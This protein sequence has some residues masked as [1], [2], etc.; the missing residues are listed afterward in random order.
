VLTQH[1]DIGRTGQN[2]TE[3]TL[4]PANVTTANFG[5]L[6][7]LSVDGQTIAQ[8][9][10]MSSVNIGGASHRVVF[11]AT[12]HDSVYAFDADTGAKLWKASMLDAAH[13][14]AS[15][16][17]PEPQSDNGCGDI[18][19]LG[20]AAAEYG[21]TSTPVIDPSTGTLYLVAKTYEGTY[22][23]QRLHALDIT[24][25]NEK[26]SGPVTISASV[27]GTGS[28]SSNGTLNFDPRWENQ[29]S[30]LLL[31][32]GNVYAGFGSHCD[33]S[34]W[35]GWILG[36]NA[37][38]LAQT[39]KFVTTPNGS[40]SG[41]WMGGG[42]L[43]A[44][45]Q[46]GA[47]RLFP[48]TGN[49][50]YDAKTPYGT[51]NMDYGDDIL[52]L[53]VSSTGAL[54]VADA[55]TPYNQSTLSNED[56]DV[57]SGGAL[58]LPDQPGN[59]S[60]LLAQLGKSG[61]LYLV[62]RENLG[63][64]SG[65]TNNI[66]QQVSVS[67]GLWGLPA[68]WNGNLYVWPAGG[69]LSR[70]PLTNGTL[71]AQ[72][73]ET[74]PQQAS[75]WYGSTPAISSN[76]TQSGIVWAVDWSQS[77]QVLYAFDATNVSN[78]LWSSAQNT[79]RDSAG[80]QQKFAVPT[81]A[82]GNVFVGAVDQVMVYGMLTKPVPGF[83]LTAS[84]A[85]VTVAPGGS[86][87]AQ[88]T[89]T[90]ANGYTASPT[91]SVTG[92]PTGVTA[93]FSPASSNSG[94]TLTLTAASSATLTSAAAKVVVTASDGTLSHSAS[95]SLSVAN[96]A[97][98][99]E[100]DMSSAFNVYGIF[101]DGAT[102]S[103]GGLD[104]DG[105][106]YS[107]NLLGT[108]Q[109]GLGLPFKFGAAGAA[110]AASNVTVSLPSGYFTA[111]DFLGAGVNGNQTSQV[112]TVNYSDGTSS[113]FTQSMSDWFTPQSY[114]GETSV[115][116]MAH[117]GGPNGTTQAGPFYLYGYSFSLNSAKLVS[118]ITL[119][120]NRNV[121]VLAITLS[122]TTVTQTA[123]TITFAAIPT[124]TVG[125]PLTLSATA[126]S[127]LP[128]SF[129][130]STT[131]VCTVS[132]T[133]ATFLNTGSCTVAAS[134]AGNST[135]AAAKTVSQTFTVN[136]AAKTPQTITFG[137]ISAQTAGTTLT[138]SATASSGLAVSF[139]SS[140]A[141]VCTVNVATATL[142]T[143]GTCTIVA[144]Q[145][146][147][148]TYAAATSVTQSFTVN[149]VPLKSQSITFG[150]IPAQKVGTPLSLSASA[151]SGLTVSFASSTA[152]VCTVTATTA[153]FLTSGTCT[154]VASQAG[155]SSYAAATSV[156]QSFAVSGAAVSGPAAVDLS[157]FYN[158]NGIVNDGSNVSNGGLDA[159]GYAYSA[160][161]LGSSVSAQGVTFNFGAPGGVNALSGATISLPAGNF[162]TLHF[163]GAAVNGNQESQTFVVNYTDGSSSTFTQS[164]SDWFTP[165]NYPGESSISTM[166]Y[167]LTS[168]G[169]P[170]NRPFYLYGYTL[171]LNSSKTV[172]SLTLP[173]NRNV[174]VL[175]ITLS[176]VAQAAPDLSLNLA[177]TSITLTRS[178]FGY[179]NASDKVTIAALNGF[180]GN[181]AL[182]VTGL[183]AGWTA[184]FAPASVATAGS[185][186]LTIAP[187]SIT[188]GTYTLTVAA[189]SGSIKHVATLTVIAQ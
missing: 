80:S 29:R 14:A 161:L 155:N 119:P 178:F 170:D 56:A 76:G 132:G 153:T 172:K 141:S 168:N 117:R 24:T 138:L 28:G 149:P 163:A 93:S 66:V 7:T 142:I 32:N 85:V 83:T 136:A 127:G 58:L 15:G 134:Q 118:S 19:A 97:V 72:P 69:K 17:V 179:N 164:L 16:A 44:D 135:Y 84:P 131:G 2:T 114:P 1:N 96:A 91:F 70:Y 176:T 115:A 23:V 184:S 123:Q 100:V 147:N 67:G 175:A 81:V 124:Q 18:T 158:V 33:S 165:Q 109:Q 103:N 171:A 48:V 156:S 166:A 167:R 47:A 63:G 86:V 180:T 169:S 144:S 31:V 9:L 130:S 94:S 3:T 125:T 160:K 12:E 148:G 157:S 55:F 121:T 4:S 116:N 112:F 25:G 46:N 11:V 107:A 60:H 39:A 50:S 20:G 36:Y 73:S 150:S 140:T 126:S 45:I 129:S 102:I 74:S 88:I 61:S 174:T 173:A 185:S 106:A 122:G 162:A 188:Q 95:I 42:G 54:T 22:P 101:T 65:S 41:V 78:L 27:A 43:A 30:G 111:L 8:P 152:S 59:N 151:S 110:D 177:S 68:Y 51:N 92:L 104:N 128:V 186:T 6:F 52:R 34:S 21:I 143:S 90:P 181:V 183:P 79:T 82:D 71:S 139:A 75:G 89:V 57:G 53:S 189:T 37:T 146:G 5:K 87:V 154:I 99:T 120:A 64:Y 108:S 113:T 38:T 137:A 26:F 77:P 98:S 145:S 159:D 133:T 62:N 35:H 10:Y 13:G 49:G 182:A 105:Y 40:S 187:R